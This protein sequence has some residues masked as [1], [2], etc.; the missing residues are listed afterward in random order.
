MSSFADYQRRPVWRRAWDRL[1]NK[2]NW[3]FRKQ[4][5]VFRF[6]PA[7]TP[8]PN[9][10]DFRIEPFECGELLRSPVAEAIIRHT[11]PHVLDGDVMEIRQGAVLWAGFWGDTVVGTAVTRRGEGFARWLIPLEPKDRV[12][13]RLKTLPPYRG[14]GIGAF[15]LRAVA[16][17]KPAGGGDAYADC[18]V[19][20]T[21]SIRTIEKAG[22]RLVATV[23]SLTR[24][25][26]LGAS[27]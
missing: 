14:R 24:E 10:G 4:Q 23:K 8:P 3:T 16:L 13:F 20:N 9:P 7:A 11:G 12:L 5:H 26:A 6:D 2:Y 1:I 18:R 19:F 22:F 21:A 25:Q 17:Q 27:A 15:L